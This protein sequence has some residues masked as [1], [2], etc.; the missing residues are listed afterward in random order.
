MKAEAGEQKD[1]KSRKII[2]AI[3]SLFE[4]AL[5]RKAIPN[6]AGFIRKFIL[7]TNVSFS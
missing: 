1:P 3:R 6:K 4:I 5:S 7:G 2:V